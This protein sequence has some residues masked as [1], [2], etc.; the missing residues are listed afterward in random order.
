MNKWHLTDA[1]GKRIYIEG[2]AEKI[3]R[4]IQ[5]NGVRL[6]DRDGKA[7]KV[8]VTKYPDKVVTT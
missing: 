5:E 8:I 4:S 2:D 6:V 1:T 3:L 7:L